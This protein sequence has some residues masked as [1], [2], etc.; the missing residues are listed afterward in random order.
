MIPPPDLDKSVW[1]RN[2]RADSFLTQPRSHVL[3]SAC[4]IGEL[5]RESKEGGY[6]TRKLLET[7]RTIGAD[8]VTYTTVF[9]YIEEL[10]E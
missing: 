5:A 6:F 9:N 1:S 8:K 3:L 7:L 4:S 10:P 2:I